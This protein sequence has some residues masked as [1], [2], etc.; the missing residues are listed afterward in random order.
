MFKGN[1]DY[2]V[3]LRTACISKK[4]CLNDNKT[5]LKLTCLSQFARPSELS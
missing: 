4:P 3:S 2:A 1:L 5:Q